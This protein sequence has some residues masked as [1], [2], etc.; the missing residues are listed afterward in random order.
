MKAAE[1]GIE[2]DIPRAEDGPRCPVIDDGTRGAAQ[3]GQAPPVSRST[4]SVIRAAGL[5]AG[6]NL[7][8][9]ALRIVG[10][11][12]TSRFV[13]PVVLGQYNG[14]GL[15][16]GYAPFLQ[17]GVSNGL[18]RDLPYTLGMGDTARAQ[19]LA[20]AAQWWSL[21][22]AVVASGALAL[23]GIWQV[24]LGRFDL[25]AGWWSFSIVVF[26]T[27]FGQGYLNALFRTSGDFGVLA[28]VHLIGGVFAL[29]LVVLV[30]WLEWWGLCLRGLLVAAIGLALLWRARPLRVMPTYDSS[31]LLS[32]ARTG[33]PIMAVGQA[34][35]W[36]STLNSTLVLRYAGTEGLGLYA[37]ANLA[38]PAVLLLTGAFGQV[39]YPR[40]SEEFGRSGRVRDLV[41][42]S[43]GPTV[44]SVAA[45]S[46]AVTAAWFIL[47]AFVELVLPKYTAGIGAAQWAVVAAGLMAIAPV[48]NVFNVVKKQGRYGAAILFGI[49]VYVASLQFLMRG[50]VDLID[51][52]CALLVGRVAFLV[53]CG[54]MII[55]MMVSE[56]K[57]EPLRG[58]RSDD[59]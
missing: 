17:A 38:G 48:N 20:A 52:P 35:M 57:A 26:G 27:L 28:R 47:P 7:V 46:V 32:L 9:M 16:N 45:T 42:L 44:V 49:G 36:W 33:L 14:I 50:G 59:R 13:D 11:V 25:A 31:V 51:F 58:Y 8:T 15:V 10:G 30:W 6:S 19:G 18:N 39:I 22:V 53:A 1:T 43:L 21:C 37:I 5:F 2:A 56:R 23:V 3:P 4:P 40:M 41:R 34:Y 29:A 55:E 54:A 12:L 24:M